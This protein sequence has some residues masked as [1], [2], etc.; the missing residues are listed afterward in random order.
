MKIE[1]KMPALH[2]EDKSIL[3][4]WNVDVGDIVNPGDTILEA[5]CDKV[6]HTVDADQKM[7][8]CSILFEE[9]DEVEPGAVI[10]LAESVN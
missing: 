5:E 7:K 4:A 2:G 10:A 8:I 6:V 1:I 9:G 3:C